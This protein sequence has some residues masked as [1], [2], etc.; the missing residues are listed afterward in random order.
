[1]KIVYAPDALGNSLP[2]VSIVSILEKKGRKYFPECNVV[3]V[4]ISDGDKGVLDALCPILGGKS[5]PQ[6]FRIIWVNVQK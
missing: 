5:V 4:P 3:K 2:A 1:M 6:E